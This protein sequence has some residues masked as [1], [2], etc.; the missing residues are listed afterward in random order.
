MASWSR[1]TVGDIERVT[2]RDTATN[3][4]IG[5]SEGKIYFLREVI[6][7]QVS[8]WWPTNEEQ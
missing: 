8:E 7:R 4:T 1:V 5:D 2:S 3:Q 6:Q